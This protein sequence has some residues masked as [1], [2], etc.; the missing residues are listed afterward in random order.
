[1]DRQDYVLAVLATA[2]GAP[3]TPV[4]VQKLFF[5]L[6]KKLGEQVGGPW[7]NFAAYDYG[8][9][10]SN[11]YRE[12]ERL[13]VRGEAAVDANAPFTM[14]TYRLTPD[15]QKRGEAL[16]RELDEGTRGYVAE[17]SKW[18]RMLSFNQL[19]SAVY[20]DFPDMKVNSVFRG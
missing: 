13:A 3:L 12:I 2:G 11:V 18:V 19:V 16:F 15:G 8:P 17:L 1:M 4:K 10:D 5:L 14:K 9:F 6:D 20:R 7:F